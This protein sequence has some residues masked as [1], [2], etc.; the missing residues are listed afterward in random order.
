[1]KQNVLFPERARIFS[2]SGMKALALFAM[3]VDHSAICFSPLLGKYLFTLMGVRFTPYILMRGFG[4]IAFPIFCFL[5][6]EGYR[7]TRDRKRYALSM[8]L[9]ALLSEVPYNLFNVG[10]LSYPH[11]NVFFTLLLGFLGI[12][13]L[14]HFRDRLWL[15]ALATLGLFAV[16]VYLEADYG[17]TGFCFVLMMYFLGEQPLVQL[18]TGVILLPWRAGVA[19]AYLPMNLYNGKRGFI[20]GPVLKYACYAFY[21]LHLLLLWQLHKHF[22]GY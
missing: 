12:W 6:G 4:R 20:R 11:Q 2:G 5:L 13:A 7:H 9:F 21:P 10:A 3:L 19:L 15:G 22:F 14:E 17:W 1:M 8:L 18:F 16:S